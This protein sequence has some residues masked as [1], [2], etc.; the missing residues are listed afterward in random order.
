MTVEPP[1]QGDVH[2]LAFVS[3]GERPATGLGGGAEGSPEAA[4]R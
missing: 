2:L 4:G 1:I 3:A